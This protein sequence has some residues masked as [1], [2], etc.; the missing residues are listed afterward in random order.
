MLMANGDVKL[1]SSPV[2]GG[3]SFLMDLAKTG[4]GALINGVGSY[5]SMKAQSAEQRKMLD[6]QWEKMYSPQAQVRNLTSAGVNPAVAFGNQSPVLNS[7]GQL[8]SVEAPTFGIGTTSLSDL[9]NYIKAKADAK[10]SGS[11]SRKLDA[12]ADALI[13]ENQLNYIFKK[14]ERVANIISAYN[15]IQLQNDEH[16]RNEWITAKEK[17]LSELSGIQKDTAQKVFD[18]MDTQIALENKQ[19]QEDIKLTQERQKTEKT[20]QS[21]NVASANASN[22]QAD[23]NRQVRRLQ[24]ALADIEESGKTYKIESLIS[25][26]EK[27][28]FISDADAQEAN[29]KLA[30]LRELEY[31]RDSR[32]FGEVDN[33]LEWIKGKVSIFH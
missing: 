10:R 22:T 6:Y 28:K 12:E 8:G 11:D 16:S 14:R 19:R 20:S 21:A 5:L 32:L 31:K 7:G 27:N 25:E 29:I 9:A 2:G 13:F 1:E 33:F 23:V 3:S 17:A 18:N 4:A 24:S 26:Y 30:R 15:A